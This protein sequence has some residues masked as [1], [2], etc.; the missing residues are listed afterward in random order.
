M[1]RMAD[2]EVL[3]LR[4]VNL[5]RVARYSL[6]LG[7]KWWAFIFCRWLVVKTDLSNLSQTIPYLITEPI[8]WVSYVISQDHN[9]VE[10]FFLSILLIS[11][12]PY[13]L[14]SP[15]SLHAGISCNGNAYQTVGNCFFIIT[16]QKYFWV[17]VSP[18]YQWSLSKASLIFK[19]RTNGNPT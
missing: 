19:P 4:G 9:Y 18:K 10:C 7:F 6:M 15:S 8:R 17:I 5:D 13:V 14:P 16:R 12:L 11:N 2:W 3:A 1:S